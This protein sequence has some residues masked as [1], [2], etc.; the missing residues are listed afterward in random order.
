MTNNQNTNQS[1]DSHQL[2]EEKENLRSLRMGTAPVPG[3]LISMA[4]P[5]ML[6]MLVQALYN[7]VD[8]IFVSKICEEALT[9]VSIAFPLQNF[10][11]AL[12]AGTCVGVNSLLSRSLGEQNHT[13]AN[14]AAGNGILLAFINFIICLLIGIFGSKAF[15]GTQTDDAVIA[16]YGYDYLSIVM[17][18]S[19]GL[20]GQ[21]IM[22]RLLQSTGRTLLSMFSQGIGA[23]VN[24]IMDPI[25]IFGLFGFPEMGIKGAAV[26]T[27]IG[28]CIAFIIGIIF[29]LKMNK[30]IKL[31]FKS[32]IPD[33][34]I[35][36]KIYAVGF[37]SIIM[38]SIGSIM[39]YCMNRILTVFSSTAVAVFGV[40]FK[41]QSFF[42]MPIIG[43][44]NALVPI[45]AYNYGANKKDRLIQAYK[46]GLLFSYIIMAIGLIIFEIMPEAL[47]SLFDAS[48]DMLEIG[49]PAIRTIGTHFVFAPFCIITCTMFQALGNGIFSMVVSICRQLVVLIPSAWLLSL[50]G[51]VNAVWWSFPIAECA[52]AL[53]C[54]ILF[55]VLYNKRLK[56]M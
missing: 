11:I 55:K 49:I 52:S 12:S 36:G 42:F 46:V 22:E 37:P 24:I 44:N 19:F 28:Q 40:Y 54:T 7:I 34:G 45:V 38:L 56:S 27:V 50:I 43:M 32:L 51:K 29:N 2:L 4:I 35:I 18:Y 20:F 8:S 47:F 3:L 30:D 21:M 5:M 53:I 13:R 48:S 16:A 23:I 39:T 1:T 14:R 6:S 31:S 41:L 17:I 33:F 10:M 25:L 9:A 15:I 26:A